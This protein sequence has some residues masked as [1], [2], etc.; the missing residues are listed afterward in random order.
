LTILHV[1]IDDTDSKKGMCTTY[2]TAVILDE[3]DKLN[4]KPIDFPKL[5]R[6]NPNCPYKTRG[7]AALSF[8]LQIDDEMVNMIKKLVLENVERYADLKEKGTDPGVA[9]LCGRIPQRL[10]EFSR[11]AM[12]EILTIKEAI[13]LSRDIGAQLYRYK[14]GRGIIGALAAIGS[15][16]ERNNTFELIT[17]R[18]PKNR[19]TKRNIDLQSVIEMDRLT[20]HTLL[21]ISTTNQ[22]KYE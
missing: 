19:G 11:R 20:F 15:N 9:F 21:T 7:N 3:L 12:Y 8:S 18:L 17:Y 13:Q 4:I 16:L 14:Y 2:L 6:L 1:G 22:R 5:I 10:N